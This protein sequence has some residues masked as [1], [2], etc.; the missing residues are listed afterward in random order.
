MN[1]RSFCKHLSLIPLVM[2]AGAGCG[3]HHKSKPAPGL[4]PGTTGGAWLGYITVGPY[5]V[6][7]H[8]SWT[9]KQIQCLRAGID[10]HWVF[11]AGSRR[12]TLRVGA[13]HSGRIWVHGPGSGPVG[14]STCLGSGPGQA[15]HIYPGD[16]RLHGLSRAIDIHQDPLLE[17]GSQ[18]PFRFAEVDLD[19]AAGVVDAYVRQQFIGCH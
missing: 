8:K 13:H 5:E 3:P 11:W 6:Y 19:D 12:A 18:N 15:I 10:S 9:P 1:R 14:T 2:L 7:F 4:V 17:N 16:H